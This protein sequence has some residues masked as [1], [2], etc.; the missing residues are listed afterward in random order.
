MFT[1]RL[2][3]LIGFAALSASP[4]WAQVGT[5]EPGNKPEIETEAEPEVEAET[6]TDCVENK[7]CQ[8]VQSEDDKQKA[9][10][11]PAEVVKPPEAVED[12]PQPQT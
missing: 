3:Y 5:G 4:A 11:D 1:I 2:L 7:T 8:K 10:Q 6:P 9:Q 12:E